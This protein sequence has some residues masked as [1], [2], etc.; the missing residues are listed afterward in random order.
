[1]DTQSQNLLNRLYQKHLPDFQAQLATQVASQIAQ[2][3]IENQ[4]KTLGIEIAVLDGFLGACG[5]G[6]PTD[7]P[8]VTMSN[9]SLGNAQAIQLQ[10]LAFP[11]ADNALDLTLTI[12]SWQMTGNWEFG[13]QCVQFLPEQVNKACATTQALRAMAAVNGTNIDTDV[14]L[15]YLRHFRDELKQTQLGQAYVQKYETNQDEVQ[16]LLET[17]ADVKRVFTDNHALDLLNNVILLVQDYPNVMLDKDKVM[18]SLVN[19]A[20]VLTRYGSPQLRAAIVY[21]KNEVPKYAGMS[22]AQIMD[23]LTNSSPRDIAATEPGAEADMA[24]DLFIEA[25]TAPSFTKNLNLQSRG[26]GSTRTKGGTFFDTIKDSTLNIK[27][28]LDLSGAKPQFKVRLSDGGTGITATVDDIQVGTT[29]TLNGDDSLTQKFGS[30]IGT[31][32]AERF[33]PKQTKSAIIDQFQQAAFAQK[34]T[35]TLNNAISQSWNL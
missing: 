14:N 25:D 19:L 26:V 20:R 31:F 21:A 12:G 29:P 34:L 2:T 8:W 30:V 32:I 6:A 4:Q 3:K 13:Q 16:S 18:N 1:M 5:V 15:D 33:G 27:V 22:K 9:I 24:V 7:K 10:P 17:N 11:S 23:A 28:Q 35:E